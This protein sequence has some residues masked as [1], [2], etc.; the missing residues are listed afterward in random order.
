MVN[1]NIENSGKESTEFSKG[2]F[3]KKKKVVNGIVHKGDFVDLEYTGFAN[4]EVFDSN[5]EEDF[6]KMNNNPGDKPKKLVIAIGQGFVVPGL[7][8]ALEGKEVGKFYEVDVKFKEGF[9]ERKRELVKIIPLRV[10]TDK[11]VNPYPGLTLAM[12]DTLARIITVSGARVVTDFN[13]PLAGKD[14]HYKFKIARK[15]DDEK[16]KASSLFESLLGFAPEFEVKNDIIL[17]G[18]KE[19]A[20]I[21]KM[22]G[23][24]FK[25]VLGKDIKLEIKED[26]AEDKKDKMDEKKEHVHGPDCDHEH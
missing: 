25:E 16:E 12:D 18:P 22:L 7:D 4:G 8:K 19:F 1:V 3:P 23:K 2:Q 24:R 6:K 9:G 26:K 17:K 14:L 13:N 15:V 5:I 10:F 11:Q 20:A 21:V